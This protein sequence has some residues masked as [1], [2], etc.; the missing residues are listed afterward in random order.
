VSELKLNTTDGEFHFSGS[1]DELSQVL[2]SSVV[3]GVRILS[4]TEAKQTVEE[5]YMKLSSHEVM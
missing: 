1:Y 5:M 3:S 2:A 4:F